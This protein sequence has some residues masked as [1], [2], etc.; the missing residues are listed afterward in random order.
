MCR[1]R[2]DFKRCCVRTILSNHETITPPSHLLH[3][4]WLLSRKKPI[5]YYYFGH[6]S[7]SR[8]GNPRGGGALASLQP[9]N[10]LGLSHASPIDTKDKYHPPRSEKT[11][12]PHPPPSLETILFFS[13]K[14]VI[15]RITESEMFR[16]GVGR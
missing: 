14:C 3:G 7:S 11:I 1:L 13:Q 2:Q 10:M 6:Y 8:M 5:L 15:L 16:K 12:L 4:A 9:Q